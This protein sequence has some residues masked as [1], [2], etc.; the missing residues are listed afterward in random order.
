MAKNIVKLRLSLIHLLLAS[1]I[2]FIVLS[3]PFMKL[4]YDIWQHLMKIRSIHDVGYPY[5]FYPERALDAN[6]KSAWHY[7]WSDIFKILH[8]DSPMV[9]V[10]I[11]H[12]SQ[13]LFMAFV[14]YF[15]FKNIFNILL[16][17]EDKIE[18]YLAFCSTIIWFLST[19][20]F[21][22]FDQLAWIQWYSVNYQ[23]LTFPLFLLSLNLTLS[24]FYNDI[25]QKRAY[26]YLLF[27]TAAI[28]VVI[29]LHPQEAGYYLIN[30]ALLAL[31]NLKKV[32]KR[33]KVRPVSSLMIISLM[34]A[35]VIKVTSVALREGWIHK[36][37]I[38]KIDEV[39]EL[40][41]ILGSQ[42][43]IVSEHLSRFPNTFN[44]LALLSLALG[45]IALI[46]VFIKTEIKINRVL[47][48][49]LIV[50]SLLFFAIP[51]IEL[52]AGVFSVVAHSGVVYRFFYA[53]NHS[54]FI[55]LAVILVLESGIL[56]NS[57]VSKELKTV[58]LVM[59]TV[60]VTVIFSWGVSGGYLYKNTA[61]LIKSLYTNNLQISG[62]DIRFLRKTIESKPETDGKEN[63][64]YVR[65]DIAP[66]VRYY[67]GEKVWQK[68]RFKAIKPRLSNNFKK[69]Y[70][71]AVINLPPDFSRD[72]KIFY[73]FPG[74][75]LKP[76]LQSTYEGS[77]GIVGE[78]TKGTS[79]RQYFKGGHRISEIDIMMATYNRM[80]TSSV[81][82]KIFENKKPVREVIKNASELKDNSWKTFVF[83]PL[84][85][86]KHKRY[87]IEI[88]SPD[89]VAGNAITMY[90]T[91]EK[92]G[93][94]GQ[95]L[96][97]NN[98]KMA[99]DIIFRIY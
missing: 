91:G 17:R 96:F 45:C 75:R 18:R 73:A 42:G 87:Y 65:A 72:D 69:K 92:D 79:V 52:L 5:L 50:S 21:S 12:V 11:I 59:L 47:F 89:A 35:A 46:I 23:G 38:L 70:N 71:L 7:F 88:S 84:K 53:S 54:V 55:P 83:K 41:D 36:T 74:M 31:F 64:F 86:D 80:N 97:I 3:K 57:A 9:W 98:E 62:K 32:V 10:K 29:T 49:Y 44:E 27:V 34:I 63:L 26:F 1:G 33:I 76:R 37:A 81:T 15:L 94:P 58:G 66:V 90:T 51:Q 22:V 14:L 24:V 28:S 85:T 43:E 16:R 82:V 6:M 8:I 99:G 60:G 95:D 56:K 20:T 77:S 68:T 78:V 61:N 2:A 93:Y 40:I 25:S 30:A 4:P 13:F 19:G 67:F 48:S 39:D